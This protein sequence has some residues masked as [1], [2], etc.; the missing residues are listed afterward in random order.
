MSK[1]ERELEEFLFYNHGLF[2]AM[3]DL[4]RAVKNGDYTITGAPLQ[5]AGI[6][7]IVN[8]VRWEVPIPGRKNGY[9]ISNDLKPWL[10][11]RIMAKHRDLRGFF[12]IKALKK[13]VP[14]GEVVD[15]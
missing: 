2:K 9:K 11:R 14:V 10:A 8:R 13:D 7:Y 5:H 6:D 3:V 15:L 1:N 4:C 12:E